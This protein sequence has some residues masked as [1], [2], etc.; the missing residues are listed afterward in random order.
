[1]SH[2]KSKSEKLTKYSEKILGRKIPLSKSLELMSKVEGYNNS[3]TALA[4]EKD[5]IQNIESIINSFES[6]KDSNLVYL[7]HYKN[8]I[9]CNELLDKDFLKI[10][11]IRDLKWK[12][13]HRYNTRG[14]FKVKIYNISLEKSVFQFYIN[15]L[16][17]YEK[18]DFQK[19]KEVKLPEN[20]YKYNKDYL[21]LATLFNPINNK[22]FN[23]LKQEEVNNVIKKYKLDKKFKDLSVN[24]KDPFEG[25]KGKSL[26]IGITKEVKKQQRKFINSAILSDLNIKKETQDKFWDHVKKHNISKLWIQGDCP[27]CGSGEDLPYDTYIEKSDY[28]FDCEHCRCEFNKDELESIS[29]YYSLN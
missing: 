4:K 8:K 16:E 20:H 21:I 25:K 22:V 11:K 24:T 5:F 1:M 6:I 15:S 14:K 17:V 7:S 13:E 26:Y 3:N 9:N 27:N 28:W 12:I 29:Y 2:I 18:Q 10:L 19:N 23:D